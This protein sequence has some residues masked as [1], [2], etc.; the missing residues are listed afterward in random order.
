MTAT[1]ILIL[2][3]CE[4][5]D[6]SQRGP[7]DLDASTPP[8]EVVRV[9]LAAMAS[10]DLAGAYSL[11]S[12]DYRAEVSAEVFNH[13]VRALVEKGSS[14]DVGDATPDLAFPDARDVLVALRRPDGTRAQVLYVLIREDDRWRIRGQE[15]RPAPR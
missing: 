1:L 15:V 11:V 7:A 6:R 2:T 3:A 4:P 5:A 12:R 8:A 10:G 9:H 14:V 13:Q